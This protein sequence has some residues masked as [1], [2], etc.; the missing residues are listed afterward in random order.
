MPAE[1]FAGTGYW[2]V[3]HRASQNEAIASQE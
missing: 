3:P 1:F 2:P